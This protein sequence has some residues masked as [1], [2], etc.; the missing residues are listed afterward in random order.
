MVPGEAVG[1]RRVVYGPSAG[2]KFHFTGNLKRNKLVILKAINNINRLQKKTTFL[3]VYLSHITVSEYSQGRLA[4]VV[5][6]VDASGPDGA[7]DGGR[8]RMVT[9][10]D[11][12]C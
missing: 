1:M 2:R 3:N 10:P 7:A 4:A 12:L 8:Q 5:L 9:R 6:G 11:G